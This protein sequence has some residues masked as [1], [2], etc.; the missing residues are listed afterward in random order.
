MPE[1]RPVPANKPDIDDEIAEAASAL[2]ERQRRFC[3]ALISNRHFCIYQAAIESGCSEHSAHQEGWRII[4]K[5]TVRLSIT[6]KL[7]PPD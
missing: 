4:R 5:P 1:H 2:T 7:L 3:E 6:H